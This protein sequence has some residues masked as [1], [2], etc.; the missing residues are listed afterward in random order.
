MPMLVVLE[1]LEVVVHAV[2]PVERPLRAALEEDDFQAGELLE[3]ATGHKPHQGLGAVGGPAKDVHS[4][5]V[6]EAFS[7]AAPIAVG[8]AEEGYPAPGQ[9]RS[10]RRSPDDRGSSPP[11]SRPGGRT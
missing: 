11:D 1:P 10:M 8:V 2:H 7:D 4:Q 6:I 3:D 5:E 9:P